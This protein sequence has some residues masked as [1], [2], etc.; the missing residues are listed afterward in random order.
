MGDE[1]KGDLQVASRR[2]VKFKFLGA[3]V[4]TDAGLLA[5]RDLDGAF[6]FIDLGGGL[7]A[8]C[9]LGKN[10]QH[11]LVAMLR[12]SIYSRLARYADIND[13]E[14]RA[15]DPHMRRIVGGRASLPTKQGVSTTKVSRFESETYGAKSNRNELIDLSREWSCQMRGALAAARP[16]LSRWF[17]NLP[18]ASP[19]VESALFVC[20]T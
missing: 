6:G 13:D 7:L 4:T 17:R 2:R 16:S 19:F 12:Q 8:D 11:G 18:L 9:R 14:R 10:K 5:L 15:V 3:Q 20:Q 1:R